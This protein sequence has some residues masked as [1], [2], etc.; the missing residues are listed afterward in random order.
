MY[1]VK[2]PLWIN[3]VLKSNDVIMK[4]LC[5]I[6]ILRRNNIV[7]KLFHFKSL[8]VVDNYFICCYSSYCS[9]VQR[10]CYITQ[11]FKWDFAYWFFVVL[12][13]KKTRRTNIFVYSKRNDIVMK[14]LLLYLW[15]VFIYVGKWHDLFVYYFIYRIKQR[16]LRNPW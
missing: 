16:Q 10:L 4:N 14:T 13:R 2:K 1:V 6:F 15:N 7:I 3:F 11:P 9:V 5:D 12:K 8:T